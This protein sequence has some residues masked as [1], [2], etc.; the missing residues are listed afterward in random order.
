MERYIY[1]A[2]EEIK[3]Q[4]VFSMPGHKNKEIFDIIKNNRDL[5][6]KNDYINLED[7]LIDII[8]GEK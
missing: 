2:V 6:E 5:I 1:K 4:K 7:I 3:G 8:K